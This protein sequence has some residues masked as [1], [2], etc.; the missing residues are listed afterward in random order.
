MRRIRISVIQTQNNNN[1]TS[2]KRNLNHTHT[3]PKK[4]EQRETTQKNFDTQNFPDTEALFL[5]FIS[6]CVFDSVCICISIVHAF[7]HSRSLSHPSTQYQL[8][9]HRVVF[10]RC[11]LYFISLPFF[12]LFYFDAV[13]LVRMYA[14][15]FLILSYTLSLSLSILDGTCKIE[16]YPDVYLK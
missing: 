3:T 15:A 4:K 6:S 16:K 8:S 12:C 7:S 1:L 14:R 9:S 10:I 2:L 13:H 11:A 5:C